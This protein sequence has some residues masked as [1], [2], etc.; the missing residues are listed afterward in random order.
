LKEKLSFILLRKNLSGESTYK[1]AGQMGIHHVTL[2]RLE[3]GYYPLSDRILSIVGEYYGIRCAKLLYLLD[4]LALQNVR[5][6]AGSVQLPLPEFLVKIFYKDHLL[7]S[8][9]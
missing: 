6:P 2:F 3:R 5:L 4:Q 1:T 7:F 9:K 8:K